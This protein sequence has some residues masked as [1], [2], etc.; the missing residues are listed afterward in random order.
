MAKRTKMVMSGK[1]ANQILDSLACLAISAMGI[2]GHVERWEEIDGE[3]IPIFKK[4]KKK[5]AMD[6]S[7]KKFNEIC[8]EWEQEMGM[9]FCITPD[10]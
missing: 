6:Y 8:A 1:L 10:E 2:E 7:I 4:K 5:K 3:D 9:T